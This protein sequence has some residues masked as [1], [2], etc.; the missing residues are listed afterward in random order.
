[1]LETLIRVQVLINNDQ[2]DTMQLP[3]CSR[4]AVRMGIR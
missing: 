2:V 3:L 4:R 1:M